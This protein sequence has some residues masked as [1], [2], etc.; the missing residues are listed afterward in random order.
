LANMVVLGAFVEK[1]RLVQMDSL[2]QSL[3][4]VMD[5][6][7]H[8]LIPSNIRSI[9]IGAEYVKNNFIHDPSSSILKRVKE[10]D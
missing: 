2:F 3:E 6:K 1:T 8:S 7:Y 10:E 9:Q 5:E 4:K